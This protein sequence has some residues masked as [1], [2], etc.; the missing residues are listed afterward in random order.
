MGDTPAIFATSASVTDPVARGD[1]PS[2]RR[3]TVVLGLLAI[4]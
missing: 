3:L 1:A 4:A 2:R